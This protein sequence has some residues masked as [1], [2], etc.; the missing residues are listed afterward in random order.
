MHPYLYHEWPYV[1]QLLDQDL[2][3]LFLET[4]LALDHTSRSG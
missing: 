2:G 3:D 4:S 1:V